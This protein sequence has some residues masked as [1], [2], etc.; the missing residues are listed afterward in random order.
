MR[1]EYK[2]RR[3]K[4]SIGPRASSNEVASLVASIMNSV[5]EAENR[6]ET[7]VISASEVTP[8]AET[9][10]SVSDYVIPSLNNV[11]S[12]NINEPLENQTNFSPTS[13]ATI[14]HDCANKS[15]FTE[16]KTGFSLMSLDKEHLVPREVDNMSLLKHAAG[17][18]VPN[19]MYLVVP[20]SET[21]VTHS[22]LIISPQNASGLMHG[23]RI[24]LSPMKLEFG[25]KQTE[26]NKI[27]TCTISNTAVPQ[28]TD[29][30][31]GSSKMFLLL[32]TNNINTKNANESGSVG[33][34]DIE[35]LS[36][37]ESGSIITN[38]MFLLVQKKQN[39]SIVST[40]VQ[41]KQRDN[42][43]E[44][45]NKESLLQTV[46]KTNSVPS[47]MHKL[48][49][50]KQEMKTSIP[51]S[52]IKNLI[53]PN[54]KTDL[55]FSN[56]NVPLQKMDLS[57]SSL[58]N[59]TS[60]TGYVISS[61]SKPIVTT[62]IPTLPKT[63]HSECGEVARYVS[64]VP[65]DE[66]NMIKLCSM[67]ENVNVGSS[68]SMQS[69]E[70]IKLDTASMQSMN[71]PIKIETDGAVEQQE[72]LEN[73][74]RAVFSKMQPIQQNKIETGS[75]KS[76][77]VQ[78]KAAKKIKTDSD[79]PN[80]VTLID[81]SKTEIGNVV[82]RNMPE[83]S[84]QKEENDSF[85]VSY[86]KALG[87]NLKINND[88]MKKSKRTATVIVPCTM[89]TIEPKKNKNESA[90]FSKMKPIVLK[91][92]ET[93][94]V[95][96]HEMQQIVQTAIISAKIEPTKTETDWAVESKLCEPEK[97]LDLPKN[98]ITASAKTQPKTDALPSKDIKPP[99]KTGFKETKLEIPIPV[100]MI[101]LPK[102]DEV[103]SSST[104][105]KIPAAKQT[106]ASQ[107]GQPL[108]MLERLPLKNKAG[109]SHMYSLPPK[110]RHYQY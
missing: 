71:T 78:P 70:R 10:A 40:N 55:G 54:R 22:R 68:N 9:S 60:G 73:T 91:K 6:V 108:V 66:Q 93:D 110:K 82:S 12:Q 5:R 43:S 14:R 46:I 69:I 92:T 89:N 96:S 88:E 72:V 62:N 102:D 18:L 106:V 79:M 53:L 21:G 83:I 107:E 31:V 36:G 57:R 1:A 77:K 109:P 94:I 85:M 98:R 59:D 49:P 45:Y 63:Q 13:P 7:A 58:I 30:T 34:N 38:K 37:N 64:T 56:V 101:P 99:I 11:G 24:L 103:G 27:N 95:G 20:P 104:I 86:M 65:L 23:N 67:S 51:I 39:D 41:P 50:K 97:E 28:K 47:D 90:L 3:V 76:S 15:V 75:V 16:D 29:N 74:E 48:H 42:E 100:S 33:T 44:S 87:L 4:A 8:E 52:S 2:N 105:Y 35:T 26:Q 81:K 17:S 80:A 84:P 19:Q 61:S 32:Q 25:N